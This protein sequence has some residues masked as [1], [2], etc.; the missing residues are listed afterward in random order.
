MPI[1]DYKAWLNIFALALNSLTDPGTNDPY[2]I[3]TYWGNIQEINLRSSTE[4]HCLFIQI[5]DKDSNE[6]IITYVLIPWMDLYTD[7]NSIL[8][9]AFS[10]YTVNPY[11]IIYSS[12]KQTGISTEFTSLTDKLN[13]LFDHSR[14]QHLLE[15]ENGITIEET[16]LISL[17]EY[18]FYTELQI[19]IPGSSLTQSL[20]ILENYPNRMVYL[21]LVPDIGPTKSQWM[22]TG[23]PALNAS[24]FDIQEELISIYSEAISEY[25]KNDNKEAQQICFESSMLKIREML[26]KKS[27]FNESMTS[28]CEE[29][30]KNFLFISEADEKLFSPENLFPDY[31]P[32]DTPD[33]LVDF[34]PSTGEKVEQLP[35]ASIENLP[36]LIE[37][38][39]QYRKS[40]KKNPGKWIEG[41][42]ALGA[43]P[44][45][46]QPTEEELLLAEVGDRIGH[47][48]NTVNKSVI[49]QSLAE[50]NIRK[51][52][53][54]YKRYSFIHMDVMGSGRFFYVDNIK[55]V[56]IKLSR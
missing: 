10:L 48:V 22:K 19:A 56:V 11:A 17:R 14:C 35:E 9:S 45:E 27:A 8:P 30:L 1:L 21:N 24:F 3:H 20:K 12:I 41:N 49:E 6:G 53:I 18:A 4:S 34:M 29:L 32:K 5:I 7:N 51:R 47:I 50:K 46:Y 23:E 2:I 15:D 55:D 33:N 16:Q 28:F 39:D 54:R 44:Q 26:I 43:N 25:N 13:L 38:F 31:Q 36:E 52:Q 40:V 42:V 37:I